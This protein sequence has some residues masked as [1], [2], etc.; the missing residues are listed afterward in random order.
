[1][2][3]VVVIGRL[4][5]AA[6]S[7]AGVVT[8]LVIAATSGFGVVNFF[9]YFTI[10]SNILASVVFIVSAVRLLRG[11]EPSEGDVAIRGASV[12]YMLFVGVV[13]TTLLRDVELGG[14]QPW[15]NTVH[16]YVMPLAVVLDWML[17][18]P[19]RVISVRTA[20][21][22]L[23][24]PAAYTV[25]SLVR[26]PIAGF[27]PYP[28]FNPVQPGGYS[29]VALYCLGMLIAFLL[30]ALLIRWLGKLRLRPASLAT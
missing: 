29:T 25:Y 13:F 9:S 28:F 16:H 3:I 17:W 30:V 18:P 20:L 23:L 6:L 15:I 14:L 22:Y 7:L 2:R 26:G 1:M 27:Y 21:L 8:Q 10:L 24:F 19:K 4:A 5:L 11:S 12:V